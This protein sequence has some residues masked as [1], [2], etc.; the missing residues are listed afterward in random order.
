[1]ARVFIDGFESRSLDL[2]DT[3]TS[4]CTIETSNPIDGVA[5][6]KLGWNSSAS[7][8]LPVAL[9][10]VWV[11]FRYKIDSNISSNFFEFRNGSTVVGAIRLNSNVFQVVRG[12]STV[13]ATGTRTIPLNQPV[14]VEARFKP[15]DSGGV[16]QLKVDGV[17]DINFSG[18]TTDG[19]TTIDNVRLFTGGLWNLYFDNIVIDDAEFPGNTKIRALRPN[20]TGNS[21]QWTPSAGNN[22]D[23]VDEVPAS[24][25]DYVATNTLDAVDLYSASDLPAEAYSVKCVQVQARAYKEGNALNIQ[26]L[27]LACRTYGTN[28]FSSNKVL[29][30]SAKSHAHIWQANPNTAASWTVSEV[31]AMEIGVKAVA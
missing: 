5:H 9:S 17:M 25:S 15:A 13:L 19:P 27:Q 8:N 7:K 26:N 21:T 20:G 3:Y 14:L 10:E 2:W 16:F 24:D 29:T 28:Y 12:S 30:T 6:L 22:W 4:G 11:A 31:N 1:M 23:C 18:D